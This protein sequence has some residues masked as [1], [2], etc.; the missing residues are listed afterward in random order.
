MG[1]QEAVKRWVVDR[2]SWVGRGT[3]MRIAE[4]GA[5]NEKIKGVAS[6]ELGVLFGFAEGRME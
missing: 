1:I 6:L 3:Q 4:C 5:W 2:V